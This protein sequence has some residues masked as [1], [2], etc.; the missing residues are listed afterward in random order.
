[1]ARNEAMVIVNHKVLLIGYMHKTYNLLKN[2]KFN[3]IN[4]KEQNNF[5]I[6]LRT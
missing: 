2:I 6:H 1:M 4:I 3:N 5:L